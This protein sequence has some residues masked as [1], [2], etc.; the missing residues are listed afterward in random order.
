MVDRLNNFVVSAGENSY[1]AEPMNAKL[2]TCLAI[3]ISSFT[4]HAQ[5]FAAA[6]TA[7]P[8]FIILL[9]D[10][11]GYGDLSCYGS[12]SIS[13]PR[14]DQMAREGIRFT[15]FH[16]TASICSPSRASILTGRYPKRCG[17]PFVLFPTEKKGL[18]SSEITIAEML[19]SRGY[20]TACIGK[21]HL[22]TLP[23]F[24][25]RKQGFDYFFG[26]P[27]SNDS[28]KAEPG[29]PFHPVHAPVELP[30]MRN[31]KTLE[32]PVNQE[33]L[34]ERYTDEAIKFIRQHKT[35]PFFLYL[36][37]TFPHKPLYASEKFR[38][39][40]KGGLYGDT[41]ECVDWSVGQILDELKKLQL[42]EN[43]LVV[44]TSDN[45]PS[46]SGKEFGPDRGGGGSGGNFRGMKFTSYEGGFREPMIARW[47]GKIPAGKV[48]DELATSMDFFPTFA[49]LAGIELPKDRVID[50]KNIWPLLFSEPNAHSPHE[51]FFY[52][53]DTQLQAVRS[54]NW[55]LFLV[56]TKQHHPDTIFYVGNPKPMTKHFP[57]REKPELY[58]LSADPGEKHEV[59]VEHP[60][61]VQRL[62]KLGEDFDG[63]MK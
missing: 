61:V 43:T 56:Q 10:D 59:A 28:S 14:L 44:F 58:D 34:T 41:V 62:K 22:G 31:E 15:D 27:Y 24:L 1:G 18:P 37:H 47:P 23:Q 9:A 40:S 45:G 16:V 32:A 12:K 21:W 52:Y 30:L 3:L 8:N 2:A 38:G 25:P 29:E 36:P 11:L 39:Q 54:G 5:A 55:K 33:T 42:D 17:M 35:Q 57:I 50:G 46:P 53:L 13:T 26:L 19:K 20:A 48:C 51:N 7:P 60:D 6:L 49:K 63:G 4:P